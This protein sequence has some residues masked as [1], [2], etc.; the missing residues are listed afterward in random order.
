[1]KYTINCHTQFPYALVIYRPFTM[2]TLTAA[3]H[4]T[5]WPSWLAY[6]KYLETQQYSFTKNTYR[7]KE[8]QTPFLIEWAP[9]TSPQPPKPNR[10]LNH[11][12]EPNCSFTHDMSRRPLNY[13]ICSRTRRHPLSWPAAS[14]IPSRLL[15]S[16]SECVL[17]PQK[18]K[19][20]NTR[21]AHPPIFHFYSSAIPRATDLEQ[22]VLEGTCLFPPSDELWVVHIDVRLNT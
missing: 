1:M 18:E 11:K 12:Q 17:S 20:K 9:S 5:K 6:K 21:N 8:I 13:L 2:L 22:K 10:I 19:I 15:E 4:H 16:W 3:I 7:W 14:P